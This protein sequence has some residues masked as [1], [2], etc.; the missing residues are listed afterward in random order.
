MKRIAIIISI[1]AVLALGLF[2]LLQNQSVL[3]ALT[4]QNPRQSDLATALIPTSLPTVQP[5]VSQ[6]GDVTAECRLI[7][8]R[9]V[10]LS[11]NSGGLV[12]EVFG[13][14]GQRV[15]QGDLLA[16]L[17]N[18]E[19]A[20]ASIASAELELVNAQQALKTLYDEAPLRAAE[21]LLELAK[22]PERVQDAEGKVSGLKSVSFNQ[23]DIDAAEA[24]LIFAENQ[25]KKA[26][27]AYRPFANKNENNL[28]RAKL[29]SDLSQ[30]QKDYEAAL[31]KYNSFF[32]SPSETSISK[33][34]ADLSLALV[35]Q[36]EAQR[37]YELLR[38]GPDPDEVALA[39]ARISN[40][41][42][43]L[44]A[45]QASLASLELRAPFNGRIV[46]INLN[47]GEYVAPGVNVIVL[48]DDSEWRV[49]TTDLTELNV[50]RVR[51]SNPARITFDALPNK[52]FQG[53]I[54]T[55][56]ALGENRQGDITYR[57]VASVNDLDER[58]KWNMTCS[59][60]IQPNQ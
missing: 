14:E 4:P 47:P 32:G 43:Q 60:V 35:Q 50:V 30:A 33:A 31:R 34:E 7:P 55:I 36:E 19:Q 56:N 51:T 42:A 46:S 12:A 37:R 48:I 21:A 45:A 16:T 11:F 5:N 15:N 41:E 13:T 27:D 44:S 28:T 2:F 49:E 29:L 22:A 10:N 58:L 20:E 40:A 18:Q 17:S 59:I 3:G 25:L 23:A 6:S 52:T 38:N 1:L 26:Q 39:Q 8:V 24:N 54:L 53:S 9:N 57:A